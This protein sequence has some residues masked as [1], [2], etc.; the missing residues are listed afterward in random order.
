MSDQFTATFAEE[1]EKGPAKGRTS[2]VTSV[3]YKPTSG[4][5]DT[6]FLR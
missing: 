6:F 3:L 1:E 5:E 2:G 4:G